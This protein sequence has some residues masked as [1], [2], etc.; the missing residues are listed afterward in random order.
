MVSPAGRLSIVG[1]PYPGSAAE[2]I[3]VRDGDVV[4]SFDG[5]EIS[6]ADEFVAAVQAATISSSVSEPSDAVNVTSYVPC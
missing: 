6:S 2:S 3:G 5:T 1:D 4:V